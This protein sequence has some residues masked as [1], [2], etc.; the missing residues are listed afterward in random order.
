MHLKTCQTR[1]KQW[2][3]EYW[4][5]PATDDP[6]QWAEAELQFS[7]RSSAYPGP[8]RAN[9]TPYVRQV[10]RDYADPNIRKIV[11]CWSAQSAKTTTE[12]VGLAYSIANNPGP[13]MW[14]MASQQQAQSFCENRL[15]P[16]IQDCPS[17]A[18]HM[19]ERKNDFK[20]TELHLTRQ[21]IALQGAQSPQQLASRPIKLLFA[22][23][24][25][26]WPAASKKEA[27]ALS[28]ALERLKTYR[29]H[30]AILS[31][32][33]TTESGPI[34]QEYQAGSQHQYHV[35]CPHCG[36]YFVMQWE[37]IQYPTEGSSE[38]IRVSTRLICPECGSAIEERHKHGMLEHGEWRQSNLDAPEEVRSYQ[39][40]ELYSPWS[41]WGA[42]AVKYKA[43]EQQY[44]AGIIGPAQNFCNSSLAMPW[45]VK[46][47]TSTDNTRLLNLRDERARGVIPSGALALTLGVDTQKLGFWYV[48]RAWGE[49]LESWLVDCGFCTSFDIVRDIAS[50]R[51]ATADGRDLHINM[52]LI[53]SGGTT[54]SDGASSRTAE[55]YE[56]CR[57]VP[58]M[59][60][61]KGYSRGLTTPWKVTRL[62]AM[63]DGKPLRGGLLLYRLQ[64]NYFK[65][66]LSAKLQVEP[67]NPGCFWLHGEIQEEG[68]YIRHMTVEERQQDGTW[69]N[70]RGKRNDL[71]DAEV[72]NLAAADILRLHTLRRPKDP[73]PPRRNIRSQGVSRENGPRFW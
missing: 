41:S 69:Q 1:L 30:K 37:Q 22:D 14:V 40:N 73:G 54:S 17:L 47:E 49:Q 43:A 4:T 13:A 70:P 7:S 20:V 45:R 29:D 15:Q 58:N 48:L 64:T 62:D 65:D 55:V 34:W 36:A 32:T 10:L 59:A 39:L 26:K 57:Q 11:L 9:R 63:P 53:D 35:P 31:S 68:D 72:Y 25:D 38:H 50:A 71:F 56:F 8:Y 46:G 2:W 44:E 16:L 18:K 42:L 52:G 28:L 60:P 67:G 19:T 5:P 33:P 21:T 61:I 6:V 27:D 51:Y 23:E 12:L 3:R 66:T 24:L